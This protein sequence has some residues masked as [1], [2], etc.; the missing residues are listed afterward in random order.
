M[1]RRWA[2]DMGLPTPG[3]ALRVDLALR[4]QL[5][6][7]PVQFGS[8]PAAL[9]KQAAELHGELVR[10]FAAGQA[11]SNAGAG[12]GSQGAPRPVLPQAQRLGDAVAMNS[13]ERRRPAEGGLERARPRLDGNGAFEDTPENRKILDE[14]NV[15]FERLANGTIFFASLDRKGNFIQVEG[16]SVVSL[17]SYRN[18]QGAIEYVA[19]DAVPAGVAAID[20]KELRYG[21]RVLGRDFGPV[22]EWVQAA[23]DARVR[24]GDPADSL[25]RQ[26]AVDTLRNPELAKYIDEGTGQ[27][28]PLLWN[29]FQDKVIAAGLAMMVTS[30]GLGNFYQQARDNPRILAEGKNVLAINVYNPTIDGRFVSDAVSEALLANLIGHQQTAQVAIA[31]QLRGAI[32]H[33]ARLDQASDRE[34]GSTLTEFV[35]HSQG[36]ING[37][38]AMS[39]MEPDERIQVRAFSVGSASW[40]LPERLHEFVNIVDR[41]DPVVNFTGGRSISELPYA[42]ERPDTYRLVETNIAPGDHNSHSFYLYAQQPEFQRELGFVPRPTPVLIT[43]PFAK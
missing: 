30:N 2:R 38:L 34:V 29:E 16:S 36:T 23:T 19:P 28:N 42:L 39:R 15:P 25:R 21:D 31:S 13:V 32:E 14:R 20:V 27:V 7:L 10:Q 37:N 22:A 3:Q 18:A 40:R 33:N 11:A 6:Q 24:A 1:A 17:K 12:V 4:E 43:R 35:G 9:A 41:N 5:A 26:V 8:T